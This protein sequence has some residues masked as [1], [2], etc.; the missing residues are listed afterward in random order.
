[1]ELFSIPVRCLL[2]FCGILIFFV[3]F[4]NI[5][6]RK[7]QLKYG[8]FWVA[9]GLLLLLAAFFPSLIGY[10]SQQIGFS[11]VSSCLLT[12]LILALVCNQL[13]LTMH[14]SQLEM[15]YNHLV[16]WCAIH[17]KTEHQENS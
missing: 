17:S 15:K 6:K 4:R 16:Q 12:V 11:S 7:L 10:V 1:M 14:L 2:F 8:I 13:F 9:F 3:M 5:Y